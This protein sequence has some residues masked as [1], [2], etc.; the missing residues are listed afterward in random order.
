M[1]ERRRPPASNES[2]ETIGQTTT[3]I[4]PS[5]SGDAKLVRGQSEKSFKTVLIAIASIG[6]IFLLVSFSL[7]Y[8]V[9]HQNQHGGTV[10]QEPRGNDNNKPQAVNYRTG[11][12]ETLRGD[13]Q[14]QDME[15]PVI[16]TFTNVKE[17]PNL[18]SKLE[19]CVTSMF[20]HTSADL[21]LL[22]IGDNYSQEVAASII[23]TAVETVPNKVNYKV[24]PTYWII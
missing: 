5:N 9:D 7:I 13:S 14:K 6:L 12:S 11:A 3:Q 22:I 21:T 20:T 4:K 2:P 16:L 19:L 8:T 15:L 18:R 24:R 10:K 23:K 17:N 1:A